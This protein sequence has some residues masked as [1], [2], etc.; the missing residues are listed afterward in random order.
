MSTDAPALDR[1]IV[2]TTDRARG[3]G[4]L[5][6]V[7]GVE[8]GPPTGPFL[9]VRLGNG[10]TLDYAEGPPN[11]AGQHYAFRVSEAAFDA[12]FERIRATAITHWADPMRREPDRINHL[13][14]GRGLY[15]ADPDGHNVELLT[16]P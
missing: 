13:N 8:V 11:P 7:L 2:R 1:T 10:V 15:F 5:A 4:F 12:A 9:P 14:G 3:G 6:Y 16:V